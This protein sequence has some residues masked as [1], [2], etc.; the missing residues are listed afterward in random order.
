MKKP[1]PIVL[2]SWAIMAYL[3]DEPSGEKIADMIA[4]AKDDGQTL[5]MSVINIGEVWYSVARRR[6]TADAD[7]A[8]RWISE[9]GIEFV[10]ADIELTRIAAMFKAKGGISYADCFAAALAKHHKATLVTGD[11]EFEQ[12]K[13]DIS[14]SWL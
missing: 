11:R 10:D 1:K 9:I 7:R 3:Q 2:D 12:L 4:D 5:L 14:I 6:S 8:L 13:N